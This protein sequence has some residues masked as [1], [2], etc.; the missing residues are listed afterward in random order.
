MAHEREAD[1]ADSLEDAW[2]EHS[3]AL[4]GVALELGRHALALDQHGDNDGHHADECEEGR[5]REL[6]DRSV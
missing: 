1:H 2:P 5:S 6:V 3:E 4:R